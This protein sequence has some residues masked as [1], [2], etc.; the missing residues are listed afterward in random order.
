[1]EI[2][3][4]CQ[5]SR[6]RISVCL[7]A[8]LFLFFFLP[9]NSYSIL[10]DRL[11]FVCVCARLKNRKEKKIHLFLTSNFTLQA[12]RK[13]SR[14]IF[15][16]FSLHTLARVCIAIVYTH[17]T[18]QIFAINFFFFAF[19]LLPW[20]KRERKIGSIPD[21]YSKKKME[22]NGYL[23]PPFSFFPRPKISRAR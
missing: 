6:S 2:F 3:I 12:W 11:I 5:N 20:K 14:P 18:W 22:S 17:E 19:I 9:E 15:F 4:S 16:F 21:A 23:F 1:M 7:L 13:S 8:L 10:R